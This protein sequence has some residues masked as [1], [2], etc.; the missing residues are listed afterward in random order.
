M[1]ARRAFTL[2]EVLAAVAFVG[3]VFTALSRSATVGIIA[4]GDNRRRMQAAMLADAAMTELELAFQAMTFPPDGI[5]EEEIDDF[6]IVTE[7]TPW[8]VPPELAEAI[9]DAFPDGTEL[10]GGQ[11][12]GDVGT[13]LEIAIRVEWF[14][15]SRE[16]FIE[17]VTL[18]VGTR[19][20]PTPSR[21]S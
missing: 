11:L 9:E 21:P 13:V 7:V 6:V 5:T 18:A 2:L 12:T 8:I 1:K 15:G 3:L 20:S 17:R 4:E 19:T 10:F 16:N 14:D